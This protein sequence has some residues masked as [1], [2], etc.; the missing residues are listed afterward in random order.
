MNQE[1]VSLDDSL[2]NVSAD[3]LA[4]GKELVRARE[5]EGNIVQTIEGLR[6]C[7]PVLDCYSKLLKQ[8]AEKRYYPAL[9]TLE[10]MENEH[11][12]QVSHYRFT[13][14]MRNAVPKLK[15]MIKQSSEADFR[16]FL[17]NIR[18]FSPKIGEVAMRHTKRMQSR[19]LD[20]I[21]DECEKHLNG[22]RKLNSSGA[23]DEEDDE[24]EDEGDDISA[25]DLIDFSPIYRCLHIYTVLN[26]KEFFETD[27]RKQRRDQA[28][29]VLQA[30]QTMHDNLE[31]YKNYIHSIVGFFIVEDHVL[32][33]GGD[34]VTQN[35]LDE[36]WSASLTRAVNVLSMNSSSC[37]DPNVLLRIKNLIMLSITTLKTHGYQVTQL[38]ELLL[39]M[40]DHY[41]EVLLQRWVN[42]FR[43]ILDRCDYQPLTVHSPD[44]YDS[45]LERFPFHPNDSMD[46][47]GQY[48]RT[49][50]FSP[51]VPEVYHQTK[52]FMYACM[53]FSEELTLSPNE[54]ASMVR[55][56][57]NLLL[58][59][60]FS[61][62]L[63]A[64][65]HKP[66]LAPTQLIQIIVD[67]QYLER[68][69]PLL[70]AFV[71]D[72]T[73]TQA[74]VSQA[75]ISSTLFHAARAE[76]EEQVSEKLCAKLD[77]FFSV[78]EEYDWLLSQSTG[79]PSLFIRDMVTYLE[80]TFQNVA[81]RLPAVARSACQRSCR[82]IAEKIHGLLIGTEVTSISTGALQQISLDLMQCEYFAGEASRMVA[83][84]MTDEE[85]L[86]HFAQ[87]RQLCNLLLE[88]EWSAYLHDYGTKTAENAYSQVQPGH[89]I[90]VLEKIREADKKTMFAMVKKSE[91]DKKK[92]HDTVLKQL[93]QLAEKQQ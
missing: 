10:Q 61:G 78:F 1:V 19:T 11:L 87:V 35:Y 53:K 84:L 28:K 31:A 5:V 91:R 81:A 49:F 21:L 76:A 30:P 82:H 3:V 12:P 93:R 67:T 72:M 15:E 44:D 16:E 89:V 29:L 39:E 22:T 9:K 36:L 24:D 79:Q 17:E 46:A 45:V 33:T 56:A 6:S 48:P 62:C 74:T 63:S 42:V 40:R 51:M 20:D 88:E 23:G 75:Q 60:S 8:V 25:Q 70:D 90:V 41:N 86:R 57:A 64:V 80:S 66:S 77:E 27:Y 92:L 85:L 34:I 73:S 7:L 59:R 13:V 4:K 52:E 2:R 58:T 69:S 68:A 32:N 18:K 54:V 65:F 83:G 37:T 55:K 50:P 14:Q 47:A 43:E 71:C 26:D 38:W